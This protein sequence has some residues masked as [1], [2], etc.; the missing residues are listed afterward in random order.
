MQIW[1]PAVMLS[2]A[3]VYGPFIKTVY[4]TLAQVLYMKLIRIQQTYLHNCC[5]IVQ[6]QDVRF[7]RV[8]IMM[9]ISVLEKHPPG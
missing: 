6:P 3:A 1:N 8:R 4:T 2:A 7:R 9:I 5:D